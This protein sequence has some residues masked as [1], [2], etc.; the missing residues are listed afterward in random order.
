MPENDKYLFDLFLVYTGRSV[1]VQQK[2]LHEMQVDL[3]NDSMYYCPLSSPFASDCEGEAFFM[4][5]DRNGE[6]SCL[7]TSISLDQ[8]HHYGLEG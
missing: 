2:D 6:L 8:V 5:L 4:D 1:F 3:Y 7:E